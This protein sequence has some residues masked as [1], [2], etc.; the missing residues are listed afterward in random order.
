MYLSSHRLFMRNRGLTLVELMVTL[1]ILAI[2]ATLAVPS[3]NRTISSVRLSSA[4]NDLNASIQKARADAIRLGRRV[5]ICASSDSTTCSNT[6]T[7]NLGWITFTDTPGNPIP[8]INTAA[9][10]TVTAVVQAMPDSLIVSTSG[11]N[12]SYLSFSADGQSRDLNGAVSMRPGAIRI[13]STIAGA[14]NDD[15]ARDLIINNMGRVRL[16]KPAGIPTTCPAPPPP[17][18]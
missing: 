1:S 16:N 8:N 15:R 18:N 6:T 11:N 14:T 9:G 7:W 12:I 17:V 5:T 10:D 4:T 2:L 3:F 13:C